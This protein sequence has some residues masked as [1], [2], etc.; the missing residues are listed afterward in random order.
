MYPSFPDGRLTQPVDTAGDGVDVPLVCGRADEG[1][2]AS[3]TLI[4]VSDEALSV[5]TVD[6]ACALSAYGTLGAGEVW[7]L[8]VGNHL[9]WAAVDGRGTRVASFGLPSGAN[10]QWVETVP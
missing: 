6:D 2:L 5:F 4:S 7:D 3:L 8:R 10:V 1:T 9:G